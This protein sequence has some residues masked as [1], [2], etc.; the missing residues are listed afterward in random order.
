MFAFRLKFHHSDVL[1][2]A[3]WE[4]DSPSYVFSVIWQNP[5]MCLAFLFLAMGELK[6]VAFVQNVIFSL[7]FL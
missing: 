4:Q 6:A 7:L 1:R 5:G 2:H 3:A